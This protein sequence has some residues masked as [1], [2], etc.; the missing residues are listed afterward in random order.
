MLPLLICLIGVATAGTSTAMLFSTSIEE[1]KSRLKQIV[2]VQANLMEAVARFDVR[3]AGHEHDNGSF[4]STM[5]QIVDAHKSLDGFGR[6]GEFIIGRLVDGEIAL[7]QKPRFVG[8]I[9]FEVPKFVPVPMKLA[10]GG[11]AG[12]TIATDYK[13]NQVLAA[14]APVGT[15]DIGLVA[16][17]DM[18][19]VYRPFIVSGSI[20]AAL[21][22]VMLI[23][24]I[25]A[26]RKFSVPFVE[27]EK[28]QRR[29]NKSQ[30][31]ANIGTWDWNVQT[32]ELFWSDHIAP[33]FGHAKDELEA[34]YYNFITAIHPDDRKAVMD[35]VTACIEDGAEYNIEHRTL[36]PDG[37][38]RWLHESGDVVRDDDGS[39]LN[40]LGMVQ[41]ITE[42]RTMQGQL[43]QSS[44]MATLGEMATGV[45]HELNQPLNVIRMAAGNI[46]RKS[47][48][49]TLATDYLNEKL[50]KID[51]MV[52][53]AASIIDHMRVFGRTASSNVE[54]LIP[55]NIVEGAM[56]LI[57]E[58]LRLSNIEVTVIEGDES[59]LVL[60]N[61]IQIE[62]V[63]LNL[64]ANARDAVKD[65][66]YGEKN[67]TLRIGASDDGKYVEIEVEDSG[68][69]IDSAHLSRIFEPFYTTKEVGHGTGL[70][71]SISYGIIA[72]MGGK[73][74]AKNTDIG[75]K[76]TVTLPVAQR[77][78]A[79]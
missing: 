40:M 33:L 15:L 9:N 73:I 65:N 47:D 76:F 24:G 70:G 38:V 11:G 50:S 79:A 25:Y 64:L 6:T 62:Q 34:T 45:A 3:H 20:I 37:T 74:E 77:E 59:H 42:R 17:I 46:H 61:Q 78:Q 10:L 21:T 19:E 32:G 68:G 41:D 58:Q 39:P 5:S 28:S 14:Y 16:K 31:F 22:L 69:G 60:G 66:D 12:E 43:I 55:A 51:S 18:T 75:A 30:E 8:D 35:A 56:G 4:Q 49:N 27:L 72:D 2:N 52:E 7:L 67:I 44:K 71:L 26:S 48:K 23:I 29:F 54:S 1:D 57:G 63:L 13:G 36:W 53:R